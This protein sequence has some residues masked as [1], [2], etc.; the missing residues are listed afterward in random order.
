MSD[1]G[2][3]VGFYTKLLGVAPTKLRDGYANF[4]VADPP[5]KLIVIEDEG[6]P[7]SIN[8]LGIEFEDG[9]GVA[10]KSRL[11][12]DAGLDIE[13]DDPHTCCYA[14]QEKAWAND[15]EGIPWE[16]YTVVEDT[17]HF[18]ASPRAGVTSSD[19]PPS[20]SPW[21]GNVTA[22]PSAL[23]QRDDCR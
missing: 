17:A 7:G 11:V 19:K 8:H 16:M 2:E 12:A 14:T 10:A 1:V 3:S 15:P 18:G 20:T 5:M 6:E 22:D 13:V 4:V 21:T 9:I 23:P